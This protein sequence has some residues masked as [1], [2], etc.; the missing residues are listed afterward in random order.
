[1]LSCALIVE[2]EMCPHA[3]IAS[4]QAAQ[5]RS[6]LPIVM[7]SIVVQYPQV[8]PVMMYQQPYID[9]AKTGSEHVR[10]AFMQMQMHAAFIHSCSGG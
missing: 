5:P 8:H 2:Y 7:Q 3:K 1:M 9:L 10:H 4:T 6:T